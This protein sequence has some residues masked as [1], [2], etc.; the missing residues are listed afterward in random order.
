MPDCSLCGNPMPEES[1]AVLFVDRTGVP[2]VICGE[3]ED[4]IDCYRHAENEQEAAQALEYIIGNAKNV[5][6]RDVYDSLVGFME[7][8]RPAAAAAMDEETPEVTE[9]APALDE[10]PE[11]TDEPGPE[12]PQAG[13]YDAGAGK[14]GVFR[15]V[16]FVGVIVALLLL[17]WLLG[18]FVCSDIPLA[19]QFGV[20]MVFFLLAMPRKK[21]GRPAWRCW[22]SM[23]GLSHT[24]LPWRFIHT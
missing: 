23:P 22:Q 6:R 10:E 7:E 9:D 11:M 19:G 8:N 18:F 5:G 24:A 21:I 15:S 4:H 3:C 12:E 16:V 14:R 1:G 20:H 13:Q 2:F 17:A